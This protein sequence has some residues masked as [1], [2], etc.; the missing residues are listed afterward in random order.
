MVI[1]LTFNDLPA[2]SSSCFWHG[3]WSPPAGG[4]PSTAALTPTIEMFSIAYK[5]P[6][7]SVNI[8]EIKLRGQNDPVVKIFFSTDGKTKVDSY[9][10]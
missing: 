3:L 6:K 7:K 2:L 10:G 8:L 4:P 9:P 5:T 1:L